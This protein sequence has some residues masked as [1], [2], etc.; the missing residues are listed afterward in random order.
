MPTNER[1]REMRKRLIPA[2]FYD[3]HPRGFEDDPPP[4]RE[5]DKSGEG[6]EGEESEEEGE[7]KPEDTTAL[8]SALQKERADRKRLAKQVRELAKFKEDADAKDKSDTDKAKDEATKATSTNA[9]LAAKLKDTAVD[10]AIIK[11]ATGLKFR[12]IDDALKLLDR[13]GVDVDQDDDD[14]SEVE[15]DEASVK[16]ALTALAKAKPHLIVAEGQETR[17]GS[18]FNGSKQTDKELDDA[19]LKSMYPALNRSASVS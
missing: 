8:K 10:N 16:V 2:I 18:K 19:K 4:K 11:L 1:K 9:K 13:S 15:V 3:L 7:E 6:E 14:P 5:D 17:S 12:D